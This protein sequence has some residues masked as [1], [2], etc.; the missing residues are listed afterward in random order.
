MEFMM[1]AHV[2]WFIDDPEQFPLEW[3]R[4]LAPATIGGAVL[5]VVGALV[6]RWLVQRVDEDRITGWVRRTLRPYLPLLLSVHLGIAL[7]AYALTGRYLAPSLELPAGRWGSALAALQLIVAALIML[8]LFTRV[9]AGLLVVSGPL[10]MAFYGL[11]PMLERIELLGIALYLAIVGRRRFSLDGLRHGS[12][13][14][15]TMNPPAVGMLR[16]CAGLAMVVGAFTE[17]LLAPGVSE[18]FLRRFPRF[19]FLEGAGVSDRAFSDAVGAVELA[20][21]L[22]LL[23]GVGTR[24]AVLA[25]VVPFNVTLLFFG[26]TELIGHLPIYGIF[27]VLL[28]EGSGRVRETLADSVVRRPPDA[29][30]SSGTAGSGTSFVPIT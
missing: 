27:L 17:K 28:V 16:V 19:N 21:G 8:G 30:I 10:G 5:A 4:L 6:L 20:L 9:A 25:A 12:G 7:T 22:L 29:R 15:P 14:L 3:G 23:S 13:E 2:K 11:A 24:L 1:L 26:V 18:A